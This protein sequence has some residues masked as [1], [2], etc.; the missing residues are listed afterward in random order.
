MNQNITSLSLSFF[1]IISLSYFSCSHAQEKWGNEINYGKYSV[2]YKTIHVKDYS[3]TYKMSSNSSFSPRPMQ[4]GVW[5]PTSNKKKKYLKL[6][7]FLF[8]E[9]TEE[10]LEELNVKNLVLPPRYNNIKIPDE[11]LKTNTH[12]IHNAK[13]AKGEFPL[14]IYGTS[15]SSSG[16]DNIVLCEVLASHGFIVVTVASKNEFNR[17]MPFTVRGME[18][19]ARDMEFLYGLMYNHKGVDNSRVG[20]FGFSFGGLSMVPFSIRNKNVK[21]MVALDAS[22]TNGYYILESIP[23]LKMGDFNSNFLAFMASK[24]NINQYPLYNASFLSDINLIEVK[25]L[26]HTDFSSTNLI[27]NDSPAFKFKYYASIANLTT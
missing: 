17:R 24:D 7:H 2:G 22:I 20:T 15:Q 8:L 10:T 19:Q 9:N 26:I 12:S 21:A 14:L 11:L 3:R 1:L 25:D 27:L 5:Y 13:Q 4:I 6:E 18:A 23:S 16:F